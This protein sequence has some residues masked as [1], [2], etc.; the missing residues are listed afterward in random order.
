MDLGK[1]LECPLDMLMLLM[2]A[3]QYENYKHQMTLGDKE[4]IKNLEKQN[5]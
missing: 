3:K 4:L 5:K 2:R 1:I